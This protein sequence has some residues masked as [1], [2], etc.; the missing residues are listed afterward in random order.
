MREGAGQSIAWLLPGKRAE[1]LHGPTLRPCA[2]AA[3]FPGI[4]LILGIRPSVKLL[5]TPAAGDLIII[6]LACIAPR[7]VVQLQVY[8]G[9]LKIQLQYIFFFFFPFPCVFILCL[10]QKLC[11]LVTFW[12]NLAACDLGAYSKG[13][14]D[15]FFKEA[16]SQAA[17][18]TCGRVEK[19]A[20]PILRAWAVFAVF[21]VYFIAYQLHWGKKVRSVQ[22]LPFSCWQL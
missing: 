9:L 20:S 5:F 6:S 11:Y 15:A 2:A 3:A 13:A 17:V 12:A 21:D 18:A 22:K 19:C 8:L 1:R 14:E 4:A 10:L 7:G 16:C